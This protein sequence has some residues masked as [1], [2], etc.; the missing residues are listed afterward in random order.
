M[1]LT[2][3]KRTSCSFL[4]VWNLSDKTSH[5]LC[6]RVYDLAGGG[7]G[8]AIASD[9]KGLGFMSFAVVL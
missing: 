2:E 1:C 3:A 4:G 5:C 8:I 9:T 7:R 6:C